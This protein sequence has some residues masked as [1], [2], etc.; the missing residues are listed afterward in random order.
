[1]T[2]P[3]NP[4]ELWHEE[5]PASADGHPAWAAAVGNIYET[6]GLDDR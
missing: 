2:K 1:M 3:F 4:L 5:I 6:G